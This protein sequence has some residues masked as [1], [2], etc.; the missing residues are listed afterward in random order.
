MKTIICETQAEVTAVVCQ[1]WCRWYQE[2]QTAGGFFNVALAGGSTP[3]RLYEQ[4]A[5]QPCAQPMAWNQ[6]QLFFGDERSVSLDHGDSNYRMVKDALLDS[7]QVPDAQVFPM[8]AD[9][10]DIEQ[11]ASLYESEIVGNV[12][13]VNGIPQLD[14]VLL[15]MG[16]DGHTASLFPGTTVLNE[17]QRLVAPV[18]VEKLNTWRMT[19]TYPLIN[20]SRHV[21]VMVCGEN[22]A[23]RI[24][25]IFN[26]EGEQ[27]FPVQGIK[28]QDELYWCLDMAAAR[29]L[30][31]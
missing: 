28:P 19:M 10:S 30:E 12:P 1:L 4:L 26:G 14:L 22:K 17:S 5:A 6:H 3:R 9:S 27:T 29:H 7:A 20:H 25:E 16:D 18:Y 8:H 11:A 24:G 15:G 13:L 23:D 21:V 2:S 31:K